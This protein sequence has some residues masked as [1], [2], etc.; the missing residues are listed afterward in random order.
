MSQKMFVSNV[1]HELRTPLAAIMGELGLALQKERTPEDYQHRLERALDDTNK[2]SEIVI[3]LLNMARAEYDA[4]QIKMEEVRVDELLMDVSDDLLRAK[5][6]YHINISFEGEPQNDEVVSTNANRYLLALAF[7]NL[8]ENNCKYS[9]NHTS[10]ITIHSF[11]KLIVT[12]SDSGIGMSDEEKKNIFKMFYRG[13]IFDKSGHGIG[14]A[15]V[16]RILSLHKANIE[17]QTKEHHG[18][19]FVVS[20]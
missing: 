17:V 7:R 12:F 20:F 10:N 2:M 3:G 6:N 16:Q 9:E 5:P 14:M 1:S 18:T 8:I 11:K 13:N 4:S 15:M 19:T